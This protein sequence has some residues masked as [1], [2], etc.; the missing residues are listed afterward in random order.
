MRAIALANQK[1]GVG[2]TTSAINIGAGLCRL[3]KPALL[4]DLDPQ[5]HA[6]YSLGI[7][8]KDQDKTVY[9]LLKGE[10]KIGETMVER[11]GLKVLPA[12]L[13]LAAAEQELSGVPGREFL[14]RDALGGLKGFDFVL[15]DCPPSLGLLTLN[16]LTAAQEVFIPMQ[17]EFLALRGLSKLME[18]VETVR[19][20][21]N[22]RLELSGIIGT[23]FDSRRVLNREVVEKLKDYFGDKL[24]K[25]LIRENI[26]LAEAPAS[27]KTIYEHEPGSHGAEDYLA[28]CKEILE[29]SGNA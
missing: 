23:R 2:K 6:T 29:R 15:I 14:L 20:R 21:L 16:A 17:T 4:V 7:E 19:Q 1:G 13:D 28:L 3:G 9:E 12:T 24:F 5:A 27:G 26:A 25:T 22:K 10:A 8:P 18:T 11:D